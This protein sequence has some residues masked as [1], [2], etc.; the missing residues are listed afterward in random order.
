MNVRY[1]K[2][3]IKI[4][5]YSDTNLTEEMDVFKEVF[6]LVIYYKNSFISEYA[7]QSPCIVKIKNSF[8]QVFILILKIRDYFI[9][10]SKKGL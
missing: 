7:T 9:V 10:Y 8:T 6:I 5:F 2:F 3:S 4:N 1:K